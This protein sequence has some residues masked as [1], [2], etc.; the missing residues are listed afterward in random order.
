MK[1]ICSNCGHRPATEIIEG[2]GESQFRCSWCIP[3]ATATA[4]GSP[5]PWTTLA[6]VSLGFL[7]S[8]ILFSIVTGG[9]PA[10]PTRAAGGPGVVGG[11]FHGGIPNAIDR[12]AGLVV[13]AEPAPAERA[14][15]TPAERA[16]SASF[17]LPHGSSGVTVIPVGPEPG[18]DA[19][20]APPLV[21][22]AAPG[23]P[24]ADPGPVPSPAPTPRPSDGPGPGPA[25]PPT[26]Q[27]EPTVEPSPTPTEEPSPQPTATP[28]AQPAPEP[29]TQ[30]T[31]APTP[32]PPPSPGLEG[33]ARPASNLARAG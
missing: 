33:I 15:P 23:P 32:P 30:P 7:A 3:R 22:P 10:G 31:A 24:D 8:L 2:D 21:V 18:D 29:T 25:P 12:V 4:T 17:S 14:R 20:E 16:P 13:E 28:S 6:A 26:P 5:A 11:L 19:V 27:P 9:S 1:A